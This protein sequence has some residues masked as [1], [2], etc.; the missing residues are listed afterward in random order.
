MRT[1]VTKY[2]KTCDPCQKIKHN[3]GAKYGFLHPLDIPA[4]PFK[5]IMLDFITSLPPSHGKDAI[6]VVVNKLTKFAHFLPTTM[7]VSASDTASLL[8][9]QVIKL[10]GMPKTMVSDWDPRW[11][12]SIWKALACLFDTHLALSTLKHPQ[13][14]GQ[15]EAMNQHLETMLRAYVQADQADWA[16]WLDVLQ[17]SYNNATHL[18]HKESPT[19]LLLGYKPHSPLDFLVESGRGTVDVNT[20]SSSHLNELELHRDTARDTIKR[21]ADRQAY[22]FDKGCR[23]PKLKVGDKVLI[24]LHSLELVD[25]KGRSRKLVQRKIGPFK[26]LEVM[27]PTAYKFRLPDSYPM[28]NVV[29]IQHLTKYHR[30]SDPS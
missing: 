18:S 23:S 11:T 4:K 25:V 6:L 10:F 3:R 28:H 26:I 21:S 15:T 7:T 1:D 13:M 17:F 2:I 8:F 5:V 12:S 16:Q 22:Q 9:K 29:N 19:Q 24:N 27:N 30:N 20:H 14:D